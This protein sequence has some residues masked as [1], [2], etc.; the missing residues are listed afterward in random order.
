MTGNL[1]LGGNDINN[2][3]NITALGSTTS[4]TLRST[5]D[6]DIGGR[7]TVS[8]ITSMDR[9]LY[10]NSQIIATGNINGDT[11]QPTS[12]N[13]IGAVC[14]SSGLISKD[15]VGNIISCFSGIW[16][17]IGDQPGTIKI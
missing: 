3:K 5:G 4:G 13:I 7:L 1:N 6:T 9:D 11:L 12:I 15:K 8:G 16:Q 14:T 2:A 10:V 17:P